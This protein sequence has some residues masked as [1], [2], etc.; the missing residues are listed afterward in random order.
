MIEKM[1]LVRN[2]L[3]KWFIIAFTLF[4][5]STALFIQLKGYG[6]EIISNIFNI[7]VAY[8]YNSSFLI[9]G[10]IKHLL[11]FFVLSPAIAL[12]WVIKYK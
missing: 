8:Y 9:L 4:L 2:I 5:L 1:T 11:I 10:L 7:N 12:H 6:A 3:F